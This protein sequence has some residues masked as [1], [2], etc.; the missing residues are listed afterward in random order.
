MQKLHRKIMKVLRQKLENVEDALH[1][2]QD[3]ETIMGVIVSSSFERRSHKVR[4]QM[5]WD[6][7]GDALTKEELEH[8]G[9]IA[10]L[11]PAEA[12]VKA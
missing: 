5:L 9:A 4:Q 7:L 6:I 12:T 3:S 10:T 11:T 2:I 1:D 8:V